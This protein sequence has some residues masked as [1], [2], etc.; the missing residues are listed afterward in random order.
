[1]PS[2]DSETLTP[3]EIGNEDRHQDEPAHQSGLIGIE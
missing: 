3:G 1:M 2:S